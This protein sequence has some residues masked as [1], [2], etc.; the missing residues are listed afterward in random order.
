MNFAEEIADRKRL[1]EEIVAT[2]ANAQESP[3]SGIRVLVIDDQES[4]L[5]ITAELLR[6]LG[7]E[8]V[9]HID[10]AEA[11]RDFSTSPDAYDIVITDLTMP[12]MTGLDVAKALTAL[13]PSVHVILATGYWIRE[14][15][16][17]LLQS[18]ISQVLQKPFRVEQLSDA[19]RRA[20]DMKKGNT[21]ESRS[22]QRET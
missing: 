17:G 15:M 6:A 21:G 7:Y 9:T 16:D 18:G 11:L 5:E 1:E 12:T 3:E 10:P 8:V 19:L 20:V 2:A 4:A 13:R 14:S 22:S